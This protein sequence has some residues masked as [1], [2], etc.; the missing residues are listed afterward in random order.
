MVRY[1]PEYTTV[2]L[3]TGSRGTLTTLTPEF[4]LPC[5]CD[6]K[7]AFPPQDSWHLLLKTLSVAAA[8]LIL[9]IAL[10]VYLLS[11]RAAMMVKAFSESSSVEAVA[12][13]VAMP[14]AAGLQAGAKMTA[15]ALCVFTAALNSICCCLEIARMGTDL[16]YF[17]LRICRETVNFAFSRD[18]SAALEVMPNNGCSCGRPNLQT[19]ST[20]HVPPSLRA[21]ARRGAALLHDDNV[22]ALRTAVEER[23]PSTVRVAVAVTLT[24]VQDFSRWIAAAADAR[25]PAAQDEGPA[26]RGVAMPTVAVT[27]NKETSSERPVPRRPPNDHDL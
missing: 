16:A 19:P 23:T 12:S 6:R 27:S 3:V 20:S 7:V 17:T 8:S 10:A 13:I 22:A 14:A 9:L 18:G 1:A 5:S 11:R 15:T 26:D 4:N 2:L 25:Q 24:M 21:A